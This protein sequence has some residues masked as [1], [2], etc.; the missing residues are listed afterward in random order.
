MIVGDGWVMFEDEV[1]MQREHGASTVAKWTEA[2]R[3]AMVGPSPDRVMAQQPAPWPKFTQGE[4][5]RAFGGNEVT[6]VLPPKR[7]WTVRER[8]GRS[9][10]VRGPL[11]EDPVCEPCGRG[12]EPAPI[13]EAPERRAC[14]GCGS[15]FT[16]T[17]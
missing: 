9:K 11:F 14:G 6:P 15:T 16:P 12:T 13:V 2:A 17:T 8:N 4:I 1:E 5:D 7:E 3:R 10:L